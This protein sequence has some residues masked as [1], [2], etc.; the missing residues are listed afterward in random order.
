MY[1][2]FKNDQQ[3]EKEGF[4]ARIL[5]LKL[6]SILKMEIKKKKSFKKFIGFI[7]IEILIVKVKTRNLKYPNSIRSSKKILTFK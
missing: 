5:K 4:I 7:V 1:Q 6:K 3:K 2:S